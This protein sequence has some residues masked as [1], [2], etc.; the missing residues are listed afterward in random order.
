MAS[1]HDDPDYADVLRAMQ[2]RYRD[3]R[4]FYGV[5]SAVI[6]ATRG[7]EPGWAARDAALTKEA[8]ERGKEVR[9]AFI[10]D[11]ITHAWEGNGKEVWDQFYGDRGA[12]NLGIGGDRTEHVIWR[13]THGNFD[14]LQPKV[15]VLMIG[16]NNTGHFMQEPAEVAVGVERILEILGN[17]SPQTKVVL[18][19][20]FPR[21]DG[22]FDE[23]RINNQAIN[24]RIRRLADGERIHWL[25]VGNVFLSDDGTLPAEIMPDKLH[26]S[27]AGYQL[28]AE[29]LEPTLVELGL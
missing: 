18:L 14:K 21:G 9:L 6:P 17:R 26:L 1:V 2:Q 22:P 27:P 3:E 5:N 19:G 7:D 20:I 28:W 23:T 4:S 15:A 24:Q 29:A 12:I 11:S 13:L 16:T 25:D 10:G 8:R